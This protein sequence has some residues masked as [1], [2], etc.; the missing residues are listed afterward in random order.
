[1]SPTMH[2]DYQINHFINQREEQLKREQEMKERAER[3]RR[4]AMSEDRVKTLERQMEEKKMV[5]LVN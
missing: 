1:M 3:D 4:A 5:G 2:K